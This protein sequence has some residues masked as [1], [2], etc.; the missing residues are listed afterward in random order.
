MNKKLI[1]NSYLIDEHHIK[2]TIG[3]LDVEWDENQCPFLIPIHSFSIS[4]YVKTLENLN[5]SPSIQA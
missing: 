3:C 2:D 5:L 4:V 1:S